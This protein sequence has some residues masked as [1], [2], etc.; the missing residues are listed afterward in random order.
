MPGIGAILPYFPQRMGAQ[1]ADTILDALVAWAWINV[2]IKRDVHAATN[3]AALLRPGI[4]ANVQRNS[5]SPG[6]VRDH[7]V[8]IKE[9]RWGGSVMSPRPYVIARPVTM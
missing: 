9:L 6:K 2:A 3:V 5:H 7:S 4:G 8:V 1:R